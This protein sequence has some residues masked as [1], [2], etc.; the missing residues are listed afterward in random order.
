MIETL[1]KDSEIACSGDYKADNQAV[2]VL[3]DTSLN[4]PKPYPVLQLDCSTASANDEPNVYFNF[5][6]GEPETGSDLVLCDWNEHEEIDDPYE[7][8]EPGLVGRFDEAYEDSVLDF[9]SGKRIARGEYGD[10]GKEEFT[11]GM[12]DPDYDNENNLV[13]R[14]YSGIIEEEDLADDPVRYERTQEKR[15]GMFKKIV[16]MFKEAE[17]N[18]VDEEPEET[19]TDKVLKFE[20]K[21]EEED[22][23]HRLAA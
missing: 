5:N 9:V 14:E 10:F 2:L 13:N 6:L 23:E 22:L 15:E 12:Y 3:Y 11:S 4:K 21:P 18:E 1:L 17:K 20:Q 16:A 8:D 19:P 7:E